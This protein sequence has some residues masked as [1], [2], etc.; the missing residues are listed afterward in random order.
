MQTP[1]MVW[2][3][4][5]GDSEEALLL[6]LPFFVDTIGLYTARARAHVSAFS[7]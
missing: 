3:K 4:A 1:E 7:N 6:L 5:G 2:G